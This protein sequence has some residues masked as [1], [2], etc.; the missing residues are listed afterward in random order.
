[1]PGPT[2]PPPGS[3][4][5]LAARKADLRRRLIAGRRARTASERVDAARRNAAH[6]ATALRVART[7]C[8]YL[9][10]PSEPLEVAL[11][12]E[13]TASG[14]RVLVPVIAGAA[15]LDWIEHQPG[16]ALR[17]SALGILEPVG[18]RIG[19]GAAATADIIVLP[20][21]AVDDHGSRLG[22]GGGHYDRTLALV[23]AH[24]ATPWTIA[25]LYD[26]EVLDQVPG[27]AWDAP[28]GGLVTPSGGVR[29]LRG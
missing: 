16:S 19:P 28:V 11:W 27:D 10:L 2:A 23:A 1:M 3:D 6:L 21:L 13:L 18:E 24:R 15:P 29:D 20:A 4:A 22:R 17:S 5:V 8:G 25:A 12:D 7:V 14:V 26:D 9:P